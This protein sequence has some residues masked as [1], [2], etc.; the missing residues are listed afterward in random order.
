MK[1]LNLTD[2]VMAR[3]GKRE[4]GPGKRIGR[5]PGTTKRNTKRRMGVR[6][7]ADVLDWLQAKHNYNALLAELVRQMMG[8]EATSGRRV[9]LVRLTPDVYQ[10]VMDHDRPAELIQDILEKGLK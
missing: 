4:A 3:G 5:P 10:L 8:D 2:D 6:L 9:F 7:P 1:K